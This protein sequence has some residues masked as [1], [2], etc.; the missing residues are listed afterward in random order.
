V[1]CNRDTQSI[2]I[3]TK[4]IDKK[5]IKTMENAINNTMT[6]DEM[7]QKYAYTCDK[8]FAIT[9][10]GAGMYEIEK[11]DSQK[12]FE[13]DDEAVIAAIKEGIPLIPVNELPESF[14]RRYLGWIDTPENRQA[15][16][17]YCAKKA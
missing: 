4:N 2:R 5:E 14:D 3:L 8:G 9:D 13:S 1:L 7:I 6:T 16:A 15:I 11:D 17:R 12:T 10:F